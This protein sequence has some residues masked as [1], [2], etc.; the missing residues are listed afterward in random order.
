MVLTLVLLLLL[1]CC[2]S[3]VVVFGVHRLQPKQITEI[4]DFLLTARRKDA[5]SVKIKKTKTGVTKFKVRCSKYLYT[6]CVQ[7]TEKA[8]KLKQSLPPGEAPGS[9]QRQDRPPSNQQERVGR[10]QQQWQHGREAGTAERSS[11]QRKT[12]SKCYLAAQPS[13]LC[14]NSCRRWCNSGGSFARLD[15][16]GRNT[17]TATAP[18]AAAV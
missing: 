1:P 17:I 3:S 5:R 2:C 14:S 18:A 4:K 15:A 8:D 7:D 6:L 16:Q 10:Q 9:S 13:T 11:V 12:F